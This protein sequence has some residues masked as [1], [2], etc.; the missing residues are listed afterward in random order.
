MIR[1]VREPDGDIAVLFSIGP[2]FLVEERTTE[3]TCNRDYTIVE[4]TYYDS[5]EDAL[6]AFN[7][8]FRIFKKEY[9]DAIK[10][11]PDYAAKG[12]YRLFLHEKNKEP[13]S[14]T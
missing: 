1:S 13:V 12:R 8:L 10:D 4:Q 2:L 11:D 5:L 6:D 14:V 3:P 9:L 7:K